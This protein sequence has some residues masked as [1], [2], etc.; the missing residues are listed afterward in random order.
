MRGTEYLV[1]VIIMGIMTISLG[2][3]IN[4]INTSYSGENIDE[5]TL[6]Q[7]NDFQEV[8]NTANKTFDNFRKLGDDSKWYQKIGAGIVAIPYAVISFPVMIYEAVSALTKFMG[9]GLIGLIPASIIFAMIAL[10][11]VEVVR[12]L[13]EFFQRARS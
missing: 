13:L 8:A 11:T 12:R 3:Y 7:Y 6:D 9:G 1:L 5:D 4:G 10:L 2:L